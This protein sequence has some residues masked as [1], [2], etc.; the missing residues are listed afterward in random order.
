MKKLLLFSVLLIT[1]GLNAQIGIGTDTPSANA[2]LDVNSTNKGLMLPRLNNTSLVS[3]PTAGLMIYDKSTSAPAYHNGMQWNSMMMPS[4]SMTDSLTYIF[5]AD[6]GNSGLN[7]TTPLPMLAFNTTGE[8]AFNS[9]TAGGPSFSSIN[10][11]PISFIKLTDINTIGLLE[12]FV[13]QSIG[14]GIVM[15]VNVYKKGTFTPYFTYKFSKIIVS[16]VSFESST[17]GS[18][19]IESYLIYPR[20]YGWQHTQIISGTPTRFSIAYDDE[21]K[22]KVNY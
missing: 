10:M 7:T 3:S 18:R 9:T 15:E 2:V 20:I 8:F 16:K 1:N 6:G 19:N 14:T 21:I 13:N 4:V 22:Q 12:L 5:L 17:D 11:A